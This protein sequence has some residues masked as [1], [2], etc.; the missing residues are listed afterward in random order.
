MSVINQN[1]T[2]A[3]ND[4]TGEALKCTHS[5]GGMKAGHSITLYAKG[6]QIGSMERRGAIFDVW[7]ASGGQLLP[8]SGI[9]TMKELTKY[10]IF[11]SFG[12]LPNELKQ[13][14]IR[15]ED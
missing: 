5:A 2:C 10:L 13:K 7:N 11:S 1:Q 15:Y 8:L 3:I 4:S 14:E 6:H 12:L 9:M